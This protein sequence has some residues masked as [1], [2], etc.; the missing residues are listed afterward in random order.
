MIKKIEAWD[1]PVEIHEDF[2]AREEFIERTG[3]FVSPQYFEYIYHNYKEAGL[4][5][6][7][8][9]KNYERKYCTCIVETEIPRVPIKYEVDDDTL[10]MIGCYDEAYDLTIWDLLNNATML[11]AEQRKREEEIHKMYQQ[12]IYDLKKV[13]LSQEPVSELVS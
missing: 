8:F 11:Y 5:A 1:Y 12:H 9:I 3:I 2:V 7:E 6:E 13:I 10:T 4:E